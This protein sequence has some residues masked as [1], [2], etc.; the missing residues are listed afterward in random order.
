[1]LVSS[2]ASGADARDSGTQLPHN[3]ISALTLA[4]FQGRQCS[5]FSAYAVA[6]ILSAVQVVARVEPNA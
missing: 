6:D 3:L 5:L 4:R 2:L 1:M